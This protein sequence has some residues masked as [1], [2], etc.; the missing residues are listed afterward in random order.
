MGVRPADEET[1]WAD[2]ELSAIDL[3]RLTKPL[4]EG[5]S[6]IRARSRA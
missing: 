4:I 6:S 5:I 3:E 1:A 2:E